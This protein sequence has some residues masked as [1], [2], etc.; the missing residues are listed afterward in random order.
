MI[1]FAGMFVGLAK[2]Q[3]VKNKW[4]NKMKSKYSEKR[5]FA[6]SSHEVMLD[7]IEMATYHN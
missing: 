4:I 7:D 2:G 5:T 6:V 1:L 3:D